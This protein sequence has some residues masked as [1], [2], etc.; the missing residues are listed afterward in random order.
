M[1][2]KKKA[3]KVEKLPKKEKKK[4]IASVREDSSGEKIIHDA[5]IK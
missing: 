4:T 2:P 5:E 3:K 1:E